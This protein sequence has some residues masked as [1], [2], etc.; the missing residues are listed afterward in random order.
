MTKKTLPTEGKK[1]LELNQENFVEAMN[2]L[3]GV[4]VTSSQLWPFFIAASA[5]PQKKYPVI[6][7]FAKKMAAAGVITIGTK[8]RKQGGTKIEYVY[9]LAKK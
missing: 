8:A 2:E 4:D 5:T 7:A 1:L 6:R 3:G 9:T